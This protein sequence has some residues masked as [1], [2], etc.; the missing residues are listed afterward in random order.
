MKVPLIENNP[1]RVLGVFSNATLR[2][3]EQNKA[4]LRAFARVGQETSLPLWLNGLSLLPRLPFVTDDLL[5]EAE[6]QLTLQNEHKRHALFWFERDSD[7]AQEDLEACSLLNNDQVD[8]ARQVWQ[9][10]TDH[11]AQNN[12]LLLAVI[13]DD[14][15]EIAERAPKCFEDNIIDFRLFMHEILKPFVEANSSHSYEMLYFF[16][17]EPWRTEVKRLLESIHKQTLDE[18]I[19]RLNCADSTDESLLK[20]NIEEVLSAMTHLEA[21]NELC[22]K[23]S[24]ISVYYYKETTKLLSKKIDELCRQFKDRRMTNWVLKQLNKLLDSLESDSPIYSYAESLRDEIKSSV[25]EKNY[26]RS[27]CLDCCSLLLE[28]FFGVLIIF[29]LL[30]IPTCFS[31]HKQY[32]DESRYSFPKIDSIRYND[33]IFSPFVPDST[34]STDSLILYLKGKLDKN[35]EINLKMIKKNR[36]N[37]EKSRKMSEQW[38]EIKKRSSNYEK[39]LHVP[40]MPNTT[41][42]AVGQKIEPTSTTELDSLE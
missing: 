15:I 25:K 28:Y 20:S 14:W 12:L 26:I 19:D 10:R 35:R 18:K 33:P 32:L 6:A 22:G 16:E 27:S 29:G 7:H 21:L 4:Q 37:L 17:Q 34:V 30:F 3:I 36:E 31:K 23:E 41:V 11:A 40:P 5:A 24:I 39:G 8:E 38:E 9:Q 1:L 2:E 13:A 42:S